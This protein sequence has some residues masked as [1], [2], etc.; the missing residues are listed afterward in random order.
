[1][2]HC[3]CDGIERCFNA[4]RVSKELARYR[5]N[6]P[7]KNTRLLLEALQ[8][9]TPEPRVPEL[10]LL[11][12]GSGVGA[13]AHG[14][15]QA[16]VGQA[17]DV[18]ASVA[19]LAAAREEAERRGLADR[20]SFRQGDFVTLAASI[21]PAD[22]VTLDRVICCYDDMP[23]LV[24]LSAARGG[25]ALWRRLSA[26]P[27]VGPSAQRGAEH[28]AASVTQAHAVLYPS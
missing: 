24:G 28:H 6:G 7:L 11:D 20:L 21:P 13:I 2:S 8:A 27:L 4:Q 18:D 17:T 16:G 10:T 23:A 1:M 25:E 9:Q 12:I 14:L 22:I 15:L 19:Y 26:R 5:R 3:Q